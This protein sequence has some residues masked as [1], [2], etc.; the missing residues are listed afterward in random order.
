MYLS[1]HVP[2]ADAHGGPRLTIGRQQLYTASNVISVQETFGRFASQGLGKMFPVP[3]CP[4]EGCAAAEAEAAAAAAA[5]ATTKCGILR[6]R[7]LLAG[8][9]LNESPL[10]HPLLSG[11]STTL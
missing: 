11:K 7:H 10:E 5:A 6:R 2:R 4:W 8:H 3:V 9:A 1:R